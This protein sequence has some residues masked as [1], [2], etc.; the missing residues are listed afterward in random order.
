LENDWKKQYWDIS[1]K[2]GEM[3]I[4][5]RVIPFSQASKGRT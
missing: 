5:E 2:M 3:V 1:P 4:N